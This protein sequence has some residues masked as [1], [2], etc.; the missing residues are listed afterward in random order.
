MDGDDFMEYKDYYDVLKVDKSASQDEIKKS[1]R[2]LAKKYHPDLH[3]DDEKAQ[4][5]FKEVNEAYEVLGDEEKRKQF[6]QFGQYGFSNGQQFDPSQYGFG[7]FGG[8]THYTYSSADGGDFSD[9]FNLFFGGGGTRG[10]DMGDIFGQ[11]TGGAGRRPQRQSYESELT[12]SLEEAYGGVSKEI[13]L[14]MGGETKRIT[15]KVPKGI[16]PGKKIKVKGEKWGIEGDIL[17]KIGIRET[18][19]TRLEGLDIVKKVP[20]LPWEAALGEKVLVET[21]SGKIKVDIKEGT[22]GGTRMRLPGKGFVDMKGK[23][24]D[25]YLEIQIVNPPELDKESRKLYEK[26]REKVDYNPRNQ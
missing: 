22:A 19:D 24:G 5:K 6:D 11:R 18:K 23:K 2:R 25:L 14:K 3:P 13:S 10:F 17:F 7:N 12:I 21:L 15:V 4:E 8:G 16:T 20:L 1:Y 9:F 26:L